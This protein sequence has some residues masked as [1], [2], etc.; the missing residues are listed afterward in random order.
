MQTYIK[1]QKNKS[2]KIRPRSTELVPTSVPKAILEAGRFL[3]RSRG[4]PPSKFLKNFGTTW[5]IL[6][7]I[8]GPAGRQGGPKI[9][10][11]GTKSHPNLKNEAQN[12][13]SKKIWNF[14]RHLMRKCEILDVLNPP[15]CFV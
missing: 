11:L 7:A 8:L 13:A 14:D 5:A 15:K 1:F 6:G 9:E 10:F 2:L 4:G 12:A 3:E